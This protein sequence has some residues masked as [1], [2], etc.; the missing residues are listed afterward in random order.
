MSEYHSE[1]EGGS[2]RNDFREKILGILKGDLGYF[3]RIPQ[4]MMVGYICKNCHRN[5]RYGELYVIE[6]NTHEGVCLDCSKEL[7]K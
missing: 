5:M 3:Y 4:G 2:L 6:G 1:S 7:L